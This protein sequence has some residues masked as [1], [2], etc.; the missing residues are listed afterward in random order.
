VTLTETLIVGAGVAFLLIVT[1][2][3]V[4]KVRSDLKHQ[5]VR[6]LLVLLD[7]ALSAYHKASGQWPVCRPDDQE[8]G[9]TDSGFETAGCVL[10]ALSAEPKSGAIVEEIKETGLFC[11]ARD[12]PQSNLPVAWEKGFPT[13]IDAWGSPV[14]CLTADSRS[15]IDR[16]AV[17]GNGGKPVFIS[18]GADGS[19]GI[20]K[21]IAAADNLRSDELPK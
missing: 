5:Q 20:K 2:L 11:A 6:E 18:A 7:E 13:L 4:A 9:T 3:G 16:E 10:V 21:I 17:A 12:K 15:H 8:P 1:A 19:F 14:R